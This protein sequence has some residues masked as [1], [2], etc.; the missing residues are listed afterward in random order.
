MKLAYSDGLHYITD[1]LP[2]VAVAD[3][4]SDDY[5]A[6]R[7]LDRAGNEQPLT[8]DHASAWCCRTA[9]AEGNLDLVH[10]DATADEAGWCAGW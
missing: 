9:D 3:L 2:A 5:N 6:P 8:S 1:P 4:L 10:P 7:R